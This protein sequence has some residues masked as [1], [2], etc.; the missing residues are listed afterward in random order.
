MPTNAE[1]LHDQAVLHR[2]RLNRYS[3][4]VVHKTVAL[5][6]R[7]EKSA[8]QR[9]LEADSDSVSGS[10][11]EQLLAEVKTI[12]S[13]GWA[14]IKS[15]VADDLSGLVSAEIAFTEGLVALAPVAAQSATVVFSGA[16][17]HA[18]VMAAV[19][20]RPFQ[21]RFLKDWLSETEAK[22]A[23]RVRDAIRQ[24]FVEGQTTPQIVRALRGSKA[25]GYKD[26]LLEGT[27][28]GVEA[29]VRTSITHT[30]DVAQQETYKGFGVEFWRFVATLDGRTTLTCAGLHGQTFPVGKGPRPPRHIG[31]RSCGA[32][33]VAE[34]EGITPF[35]MPSYQAW[36]TRQPADVQT[37]ILGVAKAKLFRDGGLTIDR[38]TDNLGRVLT[39]DQ[40]KAADA[41]AFARAGLS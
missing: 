23:A 30:A 40:L 11:L 4:G 19:N 1:R 12:Q 41:S 10:R 5:S 14:V 25:A 15:R 24:G 22:A 13:A 27:R 9:L 18:Q 28:R 36:L 34:I 33:V 21:G 35:E 7:I 6:N 20:A 32:P 17:A 8:M 39:L 26:G 37:E 16:P 31:C 38:F 29:M 2:I 3:T